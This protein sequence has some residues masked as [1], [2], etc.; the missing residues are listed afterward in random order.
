MKK[1]LLVIG[2]LFLWGMVLTGCSSIDF[3]KAMELDELEQAAL[4]MI[5]EKGYTVVAQG[6]KSETYVLDRDR[7]A[8]PIYALIW[9]IQ[10]LDAEA[11]L[12]KSVETYEFLVEDHPLLLDMEDGAD[13]IKL[14]V[15]T[16]EDQV[17]GG[18]TFP[19]YNDP[20]Y[21]GVYSL[22]GKTLEEVT[23]MRFQTW[24]KQWEAKYQPSKQ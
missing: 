16:S 23:E 21:G 2:V 20:Y 24:R 9:G 1:C 4:E 5:E 19:D 6:G 11:Y 15:L 8:C 10:E 18:Y 17:I 13:R 7:L 22:E 14:W 12:G 3:S